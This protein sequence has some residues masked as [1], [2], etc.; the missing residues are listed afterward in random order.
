MQFLISQNGT[1]IG[2]F[3]EAEVRAK[4]AN[5]ELAGAD[6]AWREGLEEWQPLSVLLGSAT[7]RPAPRSN[8][9]L[10]EGGTSGMAIG[11][12]ICGFFG[13]VLFFPALVAVILGHISLAQ[14]SRSEG[15]LHGRGMAIAGLI[16]GYLGLIFMALVAVPAINTVQQMAHLTKAS[17]EARQ[18]VVAARSYASN[19][20]GQYPARLE[21]L[22]KSG[23]LADATLLECSLGKK[24][25]GVSWQYQGAGLKDDAPARTVI[26]KSTSAPVIRKHI[27]AYNDGSVEIVRENRAGPGEPRTSP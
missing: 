7:T 13:F 26:L 18:I 11:S 1:Q 22:V 8:V 25:P 23:D 9:S 20:Q 6:L 17:K 16:M 2:P 15:S 5:G 4:L 24:Y 12:L 21:D 27:E 14:I 19:H 10:H 3:S